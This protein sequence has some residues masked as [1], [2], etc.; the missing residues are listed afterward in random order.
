LRGRNP[1][2]RPKWRPRL[3]QPGIGACNAGREWKKKGKRGDE[4]GGERREGGIEGSGNGKG[5]FGYD[6]FRNPSL[7]NGHPNY[8]RGSRDE[9]EETRRSLG[10]RPSAD[11]V[12][13]S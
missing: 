9:V 11:E 3:T 12:Y 6:S 10:P 8:R 4:M 1:E 2:H 13:S 5:C 7:R